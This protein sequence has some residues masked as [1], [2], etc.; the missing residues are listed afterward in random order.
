LNRNDCCV[1]EKKMNIFK[2]LA[3]A[4]MS[5]AVTMATSSANAEGCLAYNKPVTLTGTVRRATRSTRRA[6]QKLGVRRPLHCRQ[7]SAARLAAQERPDQLGIS[8]P[9][10]IIS[11]ATVQGAGQTGHG[12]AQQAAGRQKSS[13]RPQ[14]IAATTAKRC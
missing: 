3:V 9:I 10:V 13:R 6:L 5:I 2:P 7:R 8:Q 4:A 11:K 12:Q 14:I 1:E